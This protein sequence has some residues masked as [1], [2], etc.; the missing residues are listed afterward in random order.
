M[1][2]KKKKSEEIINITYSSLRYFMII[3]TKAIEK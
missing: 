3:V 2:A 1:T